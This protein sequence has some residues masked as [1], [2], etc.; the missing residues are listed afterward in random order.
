M[1]EVMLAITARLPPADTIAALQKVRT[2]EGGPAWWFEL[3]F[4]GIRAVVT[5]DASG[6]VTI[7]NRRGRDITF[8]YPEVVTEW[9][10]TGFVGT[11]DGEILCLGAD[12]NPDFSLIHRRDAQQTVSGARRFL[13]SAPAFFMPFDVLNVAGE[14]TRVLAYVRRR[15]ILIEQLGAERVS[16]ATADGDALWNVVRE[17]GLEGVMAKL[18]TTAYRPGR[19][20]S[21]V[22]LKATKRGSVLVGGYT[23]GKGSRGVVGALDLFLWDPRAGALVDV[24]KVGSGMTRADAVE[25]VRLLDAGAVVVIEVEYLDV[26]QSGKL[27]MPV[28]RGIRPSVDPATC[29][30]GSLN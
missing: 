24:G 4:D 20:P 5:V 6:L 11:L 27:R 14:D 28:F 2:R 17:R 9:S 1:A 22:K 13:A 12:G 7:I 16:L 21:W 30:V 10:R 19:Q 23:A 26:S 15:E 3:K 18:G 8:R 29:Q 25:V